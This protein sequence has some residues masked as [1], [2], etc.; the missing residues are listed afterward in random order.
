M[1]SESPRRSLV[2]VGPLMPEDCLIVVVD[3]KILLSDILFLYLMMSLGK[4]FLS[5]CCDLRTVLLK[6]VQEMAN[7]R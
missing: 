5:I 7:K 2:A 6:I 4:D 3:L 1:E